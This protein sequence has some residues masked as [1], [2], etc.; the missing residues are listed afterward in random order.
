MTRNSAAIG[1]HGARPR[2]GGRRCSLTPPPSRRPRLLSGAG[3][4]PARADGRCHGALR[5][6]RRSSPSG[7]IFVVEPLVARTLLPGPGRQ[8]VG[9]ELGDAHL[10]GA[11]ARRLPRS[12]TSAPPAWPPRASR[13]ARSSPLAVVAVVTL[14]VGLRDGVA[15][16]AASTRRSGRSSPWPP[17][18]ACRSSPSPACPPPCSAGTAPC[19]PT[20][21]PYVLYAAGNAGS[22]IGLLA[23]PLVVERAIGHQRTSARRGRR[24]TWSSSGCFAVCGWL[25]VRAGR[26]R[27]PTPRR[28]RR[29]P[30][31][32]ARDPPD[33]VRWTAMAA[34]PS[35]LLLGVTRHLSTDVAAIPL[36]WVIPLSIYL[37]TFVVAFSGRGQRRRSPLSRRAGIVLAGRRRSSA[38]W[39]RCRR[40]PG[41]RAAPGHL[42]RPRP[43]RARPAGGRAAAA[44]RR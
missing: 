44:R 25:G 42:H 21:D 30:T 35:L 14:P 32:G 27:P 28:R 20:S 26:G 17:P 43:G 31:G 15:R 22:F 19:D 37:L 33:L 41:H 16:R 5:R 3:R 1:H 29:S 40:H 39:P 7:L 13:P 34:G 6:H 12:P 2:R 24:P 23:Y 9:V 11:A 10:P 8:R 36:L 38:S 18:S 4:A